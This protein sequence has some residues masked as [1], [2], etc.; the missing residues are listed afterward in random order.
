MF[1]AGGA[2]V[3]ITSSIGSDDITVSDDLASVEDTDNTV[4]TTLGQQRFWVG[5]VRSDLLEL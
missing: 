4:S 5:P 1:P 3:G 2:L